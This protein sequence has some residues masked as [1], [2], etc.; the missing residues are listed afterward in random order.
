MVCI[1]ENKEKNVVYIYIERET[2][3]LFGL[4]KKGKPNICHNMGE[5]QEH[6]AK[7]NKPDTERQILHDLLMC[8][9]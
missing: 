1:N 7:R 3:I 5:F 9:I 4:K 2:T 8:G 6:Y